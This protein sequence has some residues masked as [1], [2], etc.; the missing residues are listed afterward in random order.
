MRL[1]SVFYYDISS[2]SAEDQARF[3]QNLSPGSSSYFAFKNQ[4]VAQS[5]FGKSKVDA[6]KK[7]IK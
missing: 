5:R 2:L 3:N 6:A 1:D 7:A 4:V